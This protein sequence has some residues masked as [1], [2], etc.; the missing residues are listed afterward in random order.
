[1]IDVKV[2]SNHIGIKGHAGY[3]PA[4]QDIVC[5][6]VSALMQSLIRSIESLTDDKVVYTTSPG[7]V[8]IEYGTLSEA[9]KTLVDSFF[10]GICMIVNE[11]PGYVRIT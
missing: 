7:R 2:R 5:A 1:M 8:D 11:Y 6:A 10:I 4:G 9:S 3:A